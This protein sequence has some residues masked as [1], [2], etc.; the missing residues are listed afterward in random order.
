MLLLNRI[1]NIAV[2]WKLNINEALRFDKDK[3]WRV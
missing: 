1:N 2:S 3:Q